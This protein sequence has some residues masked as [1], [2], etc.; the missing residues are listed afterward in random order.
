MH[1]RKLF[2]KEI[3]MVDINPF[4]VE[5]INPIHKTL[6]GNRNNFKIPLPRFVSARTE[7]FKYQSVLT[8]CVNKYINTNG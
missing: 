5:F 7:I 1:K 3:K 4:T 6:I 2:L 8:L